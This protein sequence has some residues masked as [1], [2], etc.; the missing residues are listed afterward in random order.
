[1][2]RYKKKH[3]KIVIKVGQLFQRSTESSQIT[4]NS[5]TSPKRPNATQIPSMSQAPKLP[6]EAETVANT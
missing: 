2:R 3:F 5:S 4:I 6:E 1:M